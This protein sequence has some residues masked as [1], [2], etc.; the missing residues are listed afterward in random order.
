MATLLPNSFTSWEMTE[1]EVKVGSILTIAQ[2]QVLQNQLALCAE[3]K[4]AIEF[5]PQNPAEYC[6]QEAYK[7][8]QIDILRHILD[9]SE[10]LQQEILRIDIDDSDQ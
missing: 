7:R 4:L 3:E 6:K 1:E 8:G 5:D 10:A 9:T 2:A